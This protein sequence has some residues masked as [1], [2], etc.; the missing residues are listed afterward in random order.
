MEQIISFFIFLKVGKDDNV[1]G[2]DVSLSLN[3]LDQ[4][5][6]LKKNLSVFWRAR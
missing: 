4:R 5:N 1:V 6:A 3:R 2:N